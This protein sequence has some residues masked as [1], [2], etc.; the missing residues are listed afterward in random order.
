M[1]IEKWKIGL[2]GSFYWIGVCTTLFVTSYFADTSGRKNVV[3]IS[4]AF[5]I[6]ISFG[7]M[8]ATDYML[9]YVFIFINGAT[10]GGRVIVA[11]NYFLEFFP[12]NI[13]PFI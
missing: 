9:L 6:V 4:V 1:C 2:I 8:L 3:L 7:I 5:M 13:K 10:F 11:Y 12:Q